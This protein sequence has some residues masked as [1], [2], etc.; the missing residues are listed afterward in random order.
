[1][2]ELDQRDPQHN[3]VV[4]LQCLAASISTEHNI[5]MKVKKG[6]EISMNVK[7]NWDCEF[8]M[9]ITNVQWELL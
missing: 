4:Y 8:G 1:M 3:K 9:H 7:S 6:F 2:S 5:R